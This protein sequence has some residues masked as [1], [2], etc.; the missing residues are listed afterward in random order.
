[1]RFVEF[2]EG[3]YYFED[4]TS[5]IRLSTTS[6]TSIQ[7]DTI[8]DLRQNVFLQDR[9]LFPL[10]ND[11]LL[12]TTENTIHISIDKGQNW[13]NISNG[14]WFSN[15]KRPAVT[16]ENIFFHVDEELRKT[17][18]EGITY[19]SI[20][21]VYFSIDGTQAQIPAGA[22]FIGDRN[23]IFC[24]YS[25]ADQSDFLF[26]SI[27]QGLTFQQVFEEQLL[28][29]FKGLDAIFAVLE[30]KILMSV[31]DGENWKEIGLS[32]NQISFNGITAIQQESNFVLIEYNEERYFISYDLGDSI[33][34]FSVPESGTYIISIADRKIFAIGITGETWL[35]ADESTPWAKI[36]EPS[37][38]FDLNPIQ[39]TFSTSKIFAIGNTLYSTFSKTG[40]IQGL[41][42]STSISRQYSSTDFGK[43]WRSSSS[44]SGRNSFTHN[45]AI[46][47]YGPGFFRYG[48]DIEE[49][50]PN[51]S[52]SL[53]QSSFNVFPN[54]T[55]DIL[56]IKATGVFMPLDLKVFDVNG[57]IV[58]I[59]NVENGTNQITVHLTRLEAGIYIINL[60]SEIGIHN[61][62]VVKL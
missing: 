37:S 8:Y 50:T 16:N 46:Y 19:T 30:N 60:Q 49:E 24:E 22:S 59:K 53:S 20:N 52:N 9:D 35:K 36:S 18:D 5:S 34:E 33:S 39:S 23:N 10:S 26:R 31:D 13:R 62:R 17:N 27:D 4:Q 55:Q 42:H 48:Q 15:I 56:H 32:P 1:M 11:T 58:H 14:F 54:P 3:L 43:N 38:F 40:Y 44:P 47:R 29:L 6:Y 12:A 25:N 61:F 2:N 21:P 57:R 51:S 28:S 45:E 7:Y 41:C